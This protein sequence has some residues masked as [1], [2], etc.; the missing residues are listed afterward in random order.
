MFLRQHGGVSGVYLCGLTSST[1]HTFPP[2]RFI[3]RTDL[4]TS[5]MSASVASRTG[6]ATHRSARPVFTKASW[7][8]VRRSGACSFDVSH[9]RCFIAKITTSHFTYFD[10]KTA[11]FAESRRRA[12]LHLFRNDGSHA[13]YRSGLR[14]ELR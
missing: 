9:Q 7:L 14:Q 11:N 10:F 12:R 6:T 8:T 4:W 5:R 2:A 1:A 3:R 13:A